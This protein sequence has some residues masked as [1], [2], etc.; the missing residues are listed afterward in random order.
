MS[1]RMEFFNK[2]PNE[3]RIFFEA[4][5]ST[6]YL[7]NSDITIVNIIGTVFLNIPIGVKLYLV[8]KYPI[9]IPDQ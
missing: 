5:L 6:S 9:I 2:Y 7:K 8:L 3:A 1:S 4:L